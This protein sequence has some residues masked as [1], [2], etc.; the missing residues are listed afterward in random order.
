M[1][2]QVA[3]GKRSN[4][5]WPQMVDRRFRG[6]MGDE[7]PGHR[8]PAPGVYDIPG[9]NGKQPLKTSNPMCVI[10]IPLLDEPSEDDFISEGGIHACP[11]AQQDR[12]ECRPQR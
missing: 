5:S 2:R 6:G 3:G 1:G 4:P 11:I 7:P 10:Y 8:I 9:A 12:R